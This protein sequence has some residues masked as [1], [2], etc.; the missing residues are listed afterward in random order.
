MTGTL[1]HLY[2]TEK[3]DFSLHNIFQDNDCRSNKAAASPASKTKSGKGR[4]KKDS[5]VAKSG[6]GRKK[7]DCDKNNNTDNDMADTNVESSTENVNQK[8]TDSVMIDEDTKIAAVDLDVDPVASLGEQ[9]L[10]RFKELV[11]YKAKH[12]DCKVS[13]CDTPNKKLG[14]WVGQMRRDFKNGRLREERIARLNDIGF[15]WSMPKG[16]RYL[17]S[18][19]RTR[20]Q[21]TPGRK[22]P[23]QKM[24]T[25]RSDAAWTAQ[26]EKLLVYKEIHGHCNVSRCDKLNQK[27][28]WWVRQVRVQ[29]RKE[30]LSV[31]RIAMLNQL[32]FVW[33][34][35]KRI[36]WMSYY[37]ELVQYKEQHGNCNVPQDYKL[38][39]GLGE[40]VHNNRNAFRDGKL[41]EQRVKM[42]NELD[43]T[44]KTKTQVDWKT[45][46]AELV[47]FKEE[48]GNCNVSTH[49]KV[50]WQLGK[51]V[52][53]MRNE[54]KNG[55][56][57]VERIDML[58]DIGFVWSIR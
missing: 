27:L 46:Y 13:A 1:F 47:Q 36:D 55:R 7:K 9:W 28:G 11:E 24:K 41:S 32:G 10:I 49:D 4:K 37:D 35:N 56:L 25:P 30:E 17:N 5:N 19:P 57:P 50:Y 53:R 23:R 12:G 20:E 3:S 16:P 31:D 26:Y 39:K 45:R 44:W 8:N 52:D 15:A 18:Q 54:Y 43:F 21:R 29:Y 14:K 6:E 22:T 48:Y 58:N 38:N 2:F 40:W 51:W 34:I 42:L 33:R